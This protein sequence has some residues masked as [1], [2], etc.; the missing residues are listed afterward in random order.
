MSLWTILGC[1][2]RPPLC[3]RDCSSEYCSK[4]A[5]DEQLLIVPK[6]KESKAPGITELPKIITATPPE[7]EAKT[8][9]KGDIWSMCYCAEIQQICSDHCVEPKQVAQAQPMHSSNVTLGE[10]DGMKELEIL[11]AKIHGLAA[12]QGAP[13]PQD[14]DGTRL[15]VMSEPQQLDH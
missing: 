8:L 5:E 12:T 3:E 6:Q 2:K 13:P 15:P 11:D 14:T 1:S 4:R 10:V 7:A 9:S